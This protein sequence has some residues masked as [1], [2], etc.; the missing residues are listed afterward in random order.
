MQH[1]LGEATA[2][3]L[4]LKDSCCSCTKCTISQD[5][6]GKTIKHPY[7]YLCKACRN[8]FPWCVHSHGYINPG[9]QVPGRQGQYPNHCSSPWG[10]GQTS[11]SY[12]NK[13]LAVTMLWNEHVSDGTSAHTLQPHSAEGL[14][15]LLAEPGMICAAQLPSD[16]PLG[17]FPCTPASAPSPVPAVQ[18]AAIAPPGSFPSVPQCAVFLWEETVPRCLRNQE[19]R[20]LF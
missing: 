8:I 14:L 2:G 20:S 19:P 17:A 9:P 3:S 13:K 7:V 5:N 12:G 16:P 18:Q 4:E 11:V 1:T 6:W 15:L 10:L